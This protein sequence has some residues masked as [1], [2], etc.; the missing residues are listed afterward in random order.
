MDKVFVRE[1]NFEKDMLVGDGHVKFMEDNIF[2]LHY[3]EVITK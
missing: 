1:Y 2:L 3:L